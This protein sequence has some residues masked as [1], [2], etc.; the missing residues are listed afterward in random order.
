VSLE[1]T[2][3]DAFDEYVATADD[4]AA[5]CAYCGR[6]FVRETHLALH[7]GLDHPEAI[8]G[9]EREA[10][11]EAHSDEQAAIRL[12]RL[13]AIFALVVIYFVF[14]MVYVLVV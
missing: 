12:F 5:V 14:F 4:N 2:S 6:P 11:E 3:E 9:T 1:P 13:K 7:R 10:F 8:D